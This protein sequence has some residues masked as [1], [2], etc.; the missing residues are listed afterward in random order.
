MP[1]KTELHVHRL[2]SDLGFGENFL[3]HEQNQEGHDKALVGGDQR[4]S[5]KVGTPAQGNP[6]EK[7]SDGMETVSVN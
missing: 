1:P 5:L 3:G 2:S 6:G 4:T 7:D